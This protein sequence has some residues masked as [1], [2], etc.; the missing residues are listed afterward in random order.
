LVGFLTGCG[1]QPLYGSS[2]GTKSNTTLYAGDVIS[3]MAYVEVDPIAERVGQLVRNQL[4]DLLHP[5]GM[6][7]KPVFRLVVSLKETVEGLAIQQDD[8][9]T[10]YNLRLVAQFRLTDTRDGAQALKATTRAIAAYNVVQSDYA[11][12]ISHK[13]ARKRAAFSVAEGIQSRIAVYFS[14]RRG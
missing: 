2:V 10:R 9:T 1:F 12:L 5:V 8:T 14:R 4:L 11:N 7:E 6:R 13:D 3:D